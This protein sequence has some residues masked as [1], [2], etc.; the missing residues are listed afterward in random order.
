VAH[1]VASHAAREFEGIRI[2][3]VDWP[4]VVTEFPPTHVSDEALRST[5]ACLEA[6][7]QVA[8]RDR[9]Q[10]VFVT[11]L[12]QMREV[13]RAGQRKITG[14]WMAQTSSLRKLVS[15]GAVHVTPSAV[16]RGIITAV[17][18]LNPPHVENA[19]VA[20]RDEA[21]AQAAALLKKAGIPMPSRLCESQA[22]S[23]DG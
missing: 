15:L 19:F 22:A 1:I 20:S 14:E 7:M 16:L 13:A 6:L 11:D 23:S 2:E 21:F 12:T 10:L 8:Q 3:T 4:I 17:F 9:E 18:W 5:L